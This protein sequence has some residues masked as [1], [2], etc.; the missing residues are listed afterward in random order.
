MVRRY[1]RVVSK[2]LAITFAAAWWALERKTAASTPVPRH[3]MKIFELAGLAVIAT[4]IVP[5]WVTIR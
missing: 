2:I 5:H 4:D 1:A 3:S